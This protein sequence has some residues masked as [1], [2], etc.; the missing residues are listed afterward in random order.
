MLAVVTSV[1]TKSFSVVAFNNAK[2]MVLLVFS[3]DTSVGLRHRTAF[4]WG[5]FVREVM[6]L[7]SVS[8]IRALE[9]AS[10]INSPVPVSRYNS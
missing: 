4:D 9:Q 3:F 10:N 5:I 6:D 7:L 1:T 2:L 8:Q